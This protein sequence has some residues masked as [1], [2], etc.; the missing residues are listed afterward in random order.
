MNDQQKL[1]AGFLDKIMSEA[2]HVEDLDDGD[3]TKTQGEAIGKAVTFTVGFLAHS[4]PN[5][6]V[7]K[8]MKLVWDLIGSRTT[9]VM[10][11]MAVKS[12]TVAIV[13]DANSEK[14]AIMMPDNWPEVIAKDVSMGMAALIYCGSHG[15]DFYN[16]K[17]RGDKAPAEMAT[18]SG[19]YESEFLHTWLQLHPKWLPNAYQHKIMQAFPQGIHTPGVAAILYESKPTPKQPT[20]LPDA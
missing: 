18:R 10:L 4:F 19:A 12:P 1:V 9:P 20:V 8:L 16:D 2:E 17:V 7:N 15:V 11:S 5:P 14:M 3:P 6:A 13:G